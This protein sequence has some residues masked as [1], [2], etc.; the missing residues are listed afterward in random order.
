MCER[1]EA[2]NNIERIEHAADEMIKNDVT[3]IRNE[4]FFIFEFFFC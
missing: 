2:K 1:K 3:N 4:K